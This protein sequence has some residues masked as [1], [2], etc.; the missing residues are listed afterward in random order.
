MTT[1]KNF[2]Q[3]R[4][5]YCNLLNPADN[6]YKPMTELVFVVSKLRYAIDEKDEL[7]KVGEIDDVRIVFTSTEQL[8]E[9]H[10]I[11][12]KIIDTANI[13]E[14][15]SK[16]AGQLLNA[17]LCCSYAKNGSEPCG[18]TPV[19]QSGVCKKHYAILLEN[20]PND[21]DE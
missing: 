11:L 2:L 17:S 10:S 8:V 6:T 14:P 19:Y 7:K 15:I 1:Q 16:K 4:V 21:D 5:N 13:L 20:D 9:L 18:A 3:L 12:G